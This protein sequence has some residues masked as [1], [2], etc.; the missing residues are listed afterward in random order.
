MATTD[1]KQCSKCKLDLPLSKFNKH[2]YNKEKYQSWCRE[3][4]T[5]RENEWYLQN[6]EKRKK[7]VYDRITANKQ[8]AVDYL[9]GKCTDCN[10]VFHPSVYDFHHLDPNTKEKELSKARYSSWENY[11]TELDKC[12][13]L[14]ANCHR[15]RHHGENNI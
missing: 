11:K 1:L 8:K 10:G 15:L 7:Q 2:S 3:C 5:K 6:K 4:K 9:G 14:C 12:V 13:L